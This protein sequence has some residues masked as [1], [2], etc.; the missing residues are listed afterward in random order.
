M[1]GHRIRCFRNFVPDP[2]RFWIMIV[3]S[4]IYLLSGAAHMASM[5]YQ[6]NGLSLLQEDTIM[7]GYMAFIGMNVSFPMLFRLRFRFTTRSILLVSTVVIICCHV[8]ILETA[9]V[10]ILCIINFIAGF[11]RM[12]A[13][14]EAMVC[15]QLILTP[16]RNYA[17]FYSVVFLTVQGSSQLFSPIVADIIHAYSLHYL[18]YLIILL[19]FFTFLVVAFLIRHY[20]EGKRIP[21]YGIDWNGFVLWSIIL[22]LIL[23]IITYGKY[24]EW[25]ASSQ[26]RIALVVLVIAGGLQYLNIKTVKRPYI[27]PTA[28]RYPNL[29]KILLLFGVIYILQAAPGLLQNPYMAGI[30]HFDQ[31]NIAYLNYY[32]L[33]GMCL[34]A[35]ICY[36][37]FRNRKGLRPFIIGGY[38]LFILYLL[39]MYFYINPECNIE[40]F[41]F[42][43]LIRGFGL[44]WL[45]IILTLYISYVVPFMHNFQSLCIIG[46]MRMSLGTPL[47]MSVI[48]NLMLYFTRKNTMLLSSEVDALKIQAS[49][50]SLIGLQERITRQVSM[51]SIREMYGYLIIASLIL[52]VALLFEKKVKLRKFSFSFPS[53]SSI[54]YMIRRGMKNT[55]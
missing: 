28:W 50:Y 35:V 29:W 38:G 3:I 7:I 45:Y 5:S 51:L 48:D 23:F 19:L 47:G 1:T 34:S 26:I 14:F 27:S 21:L 4:L 39:L 42:P 30:L 33:A 25:L 8:A 37:Y 40:R 2:V 20:R 12:L 6:V 55:N 53:M 17:V 18:H 10:W 43:S 9:N 36:Y 16:T 46:F 31:Q 13:V 22:S 24:Y 52:L 15:I 32:S 54:R 41:Y 49:E 11:F 44:L